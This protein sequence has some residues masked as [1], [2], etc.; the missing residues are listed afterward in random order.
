MLN[1][2]DETLFWS[3]QEQTTTLMTILKLKIDPC[4]NFQQY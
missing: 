4:V 2:T 1:K 3:T